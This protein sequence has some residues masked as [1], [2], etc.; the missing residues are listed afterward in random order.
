ME[1]HNLAPS[2]LHL[3][4]VLR[5][6]LHAVAVLRETGMDKQFPF[7]EQFSD[8]LRGVVFKK[9]LVKKLLGWGSPSYFL[10]KCFTFGYD[11]RIYFLLENSMALKLF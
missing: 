1:M 5:H 9:F 11:Y 8:D 6:I 4:H 2:S 7:N 3:T 10:R